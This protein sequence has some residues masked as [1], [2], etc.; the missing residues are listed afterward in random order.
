MQTPP[1]REWR[2]QELRDDYYWGLPEGGFLARCVEDG[3]LAV[4]LA[5]RDF[6]EREV[7]AKR[8][9]FRAREVLFDYG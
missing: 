7:E 3:D 5:G 4:V 2:S 8:D 1:L 6:V 9:G